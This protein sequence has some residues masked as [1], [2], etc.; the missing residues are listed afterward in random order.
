MVRTWVVFTILTSKCASHHKEVRFFN[1]QMCFAPQRRALFQH[2]NFQKCSAVEVFCAFWF[3]KVLRATR[4]CNFSFLISP[5]GSAP[6]A[7]AS[8]LF[9]PLEPHII[10]KTQC[11]AAILPFPAPASSFFDSFC[12]LIFFLLPFLFSDSS[13]LCFS[14]VH[15]NMSKVWVLNILRSFY[16][17]VVW[18]Q[19]QLNSPQA[20]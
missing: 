10:G 20:V 16:C 7:L 17:C 6:A 13:H 12:S 1:I 4:G 5:D 14:S 9:T 11:F 3:R 15:I 2:L 8:L 18:C 19:P